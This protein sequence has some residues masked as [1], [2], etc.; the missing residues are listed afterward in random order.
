MHYRA[1]GRTGLQVSALGFGCGSIGG[2]MVRGEAAVQTQTVAR[3][4]EAGITYLDTAP[5]YGDGRSEE[6]LGRVLQEL[7][8][9]VVVGTKVRLSADEAKAAPDAIRRAIEA[10][11]RRL[12][13]DQVDLFQLHNRV[14]PAGATWQDAVSVETVL[15]PI[16]EG[17][18]AVRD[19]GL[20]RFIGLTG[21]GDT[22]SIHQVLDGGVFDTVQCYVNA[23]NPSGGW[24]MAEPKEQNFENLVGQAATRGLGV[25]AIRVLAAGAL[26]LAEQ[27][28]PIAGDPGAPLIAGATYGDDL[29]RARALADLAAELELEGPAELSLRLVLS[30]GEVS[31]QG[32]VA[33]Q[34]GAP[35][36]AGV[37]TALVG[38]SEPEHLEDAIRWAER[39]PLDR[40]VVER[41][42]A[43]A[44][45]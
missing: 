1:L 45:A 38:V 5:A 29:Q 16:A 43:L 13:R 23:L 36:Q 4:I 44:E 41:V 14:A 12:G 21:L 11:L 30:Q 7:R 15:G 2:L 6:A 3:A 20:T 22:A 18:Q 31:G 19:A 40:A 34:A 32:D 25:I 37:S 24:L 42:L 8:P 33:G 35:Y 27:R 39:G 9:D 28:H 26:A 17:L 10:S